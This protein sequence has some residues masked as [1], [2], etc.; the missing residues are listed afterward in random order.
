MVNIAIKVVKLFGFQQTDRQQGSI[1]FRK[2]STGFE[3][4]WQEMAPWARNLANAAI[5]RNSNVR[6]V[7][8]KAFGILRTLAIL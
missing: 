2:R 5:E 4:V 7:D 8:Q 6:G 3:L 1:A